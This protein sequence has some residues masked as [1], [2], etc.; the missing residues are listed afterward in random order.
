M[1]TELYFQP[2][3]KELTLN[4]VNAEVRGDVDLTD[5]FSTYV[6]Q[7][8]RCV[9]LTLSGM[10]QQS[11]DVREFEIELGMNLSEEGKIIESGPLKKLK[12]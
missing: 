6:I 12:R 11:E 1:A 9:F 7:F 5:K 4:D 10:A 2:Q 8:S 3:I